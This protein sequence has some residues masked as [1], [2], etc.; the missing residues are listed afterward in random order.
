MH[1]PDGRAFPMRVTDIRAVARP[2]VIVALA[3]AAAAAL[4]LGGGNARRPLLNALV[5][6]SGPA[7]VA[8][9]YGYPLGCLSVTIL[10]TDHTY[11][12]ADFNHLT[13]CGRYTGYPTAIFHYH[14]GRWRSVLDVIAYVCPVDWLPAEVQTGLNVCQQASG[15]RPTANR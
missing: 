2:R 7:G 5:R 4:C 10:S 13:P 15:E 11:A 1:D 8:A 3:I 12:R 6:D 9:A 14:L